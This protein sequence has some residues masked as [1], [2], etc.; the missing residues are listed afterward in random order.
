MKLISNANAAADAA[1]QARA[2]SVLL[3]QQTMSGVSVGEE[4]QFRPQRTPGAATIRTKEL[5]VF[6]RSL[7]AML[8][9]GLPL[10]QCLAA[11]EEQTDSP[12]FRR[13]L[14]RIRLAVQYGNKLSSA[15]SLYP[16]V[17][18]GMFVN[19]LRTGEVSGHMTETLERL[20]D[21]IEA[22]AEL[23]HR[24]Q[25]ALMYPA[26]VAGIA[27]LLA[28]GILTWIVPAFDRIYADLGGT[29]PLPTQVLIAIS[30]FIRNNTLYMGVAGVVL[31]LAVKWIRRT[32][33][34]AIA[35]SRL[36]LALPVFG[37]LFLK[38]AM[39]RFAAALS[40]MLRNGIPILKSLE[41]AGTVV[42]NRVIELSLQRVRVSVEQGETFSAA[43]RATGR[44]PNLLVQ[45][46]ATGE[47]TGR[48]DAMIERAGKFY[49]DE[50]SVTLRGITSLVEPM[51]IVLL[52]LVIGGMVVCLFIPIFRLHELMS[53]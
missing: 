48:L 15:L 11:A 42:G 13:M 30:R 19:T 28:T 1:V 27:V 22:A 31:V 10:I 52:G 38:L 21:H 7:S 53:I 51:L 35:W 36:M 12:P 16:G 41:I 34:G 18:D 44:Y 40:Q 25:S 3:V 45:L 20:A 43:L 47:R 2:N 6:V 29:L 32:S 4:A 24:V 23:R 9:A 8:M 33:W 39:A 26:A 17:F 50:V 14:A 49:Q 5:P 37:P 46:I